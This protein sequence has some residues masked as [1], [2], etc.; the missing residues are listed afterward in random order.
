MNAMFDYWKP[1]SSVMGT[2]KGV[3]FSYGAA[4]SFTT[5]SRQTS[6]GSANTKLQWVRKSSNNYNGFMN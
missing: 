6:A 2:N 1:N 5:D 3:L 4:Y